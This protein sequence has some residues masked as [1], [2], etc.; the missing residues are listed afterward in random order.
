[1]VGVCSGEQSS[2]PACGCGSCM[3]VGQKECPPHPD[4]MVESAYSLLQTSLV[5]T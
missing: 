5:C 1:M 4:R 3:F 2:V